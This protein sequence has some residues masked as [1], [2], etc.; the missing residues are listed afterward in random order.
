MGE[1]PITVGKDWFIG[2]NAG[3]AK[4]VADGEVVTAGREASGLAKRVEQLEQEL[5]SLKEQIAGTGPPSVPE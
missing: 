4:D 5:R 2:A 3:V 1:R